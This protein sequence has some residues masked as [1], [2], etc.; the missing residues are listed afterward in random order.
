M[1]VRKR[2]QRCKQGECRDDGFDD[3]DMMMCSRVQV[4]GNAKL[5]RYEISRAPDEQAIILVSRKGGSALM[6]TA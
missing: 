5:A 4:S 6:R 3:L 2:R 1:N